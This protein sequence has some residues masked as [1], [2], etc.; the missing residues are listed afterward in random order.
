MV[1]GRDISDY[2]ITGFEYLIG[3]F[4]S[5]NLDIE[6]YPAIKEHLLGFG[7]DRLKQTGENGA[8]KRQMDS[9]LKL[10]IA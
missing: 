8:R 3:T 2:G 9:G 10:R 7:Y 6:N 1:R 4:P 5:L